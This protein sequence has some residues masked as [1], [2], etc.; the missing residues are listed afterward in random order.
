VTAWGNRQVRLR[1]SA[2]VTARARVRVTH[3]WPSTRWGHRVQSMTIMSRVFGAADVAHRWPTLP[4]L[5]PLVIAAAPS[6]GGECMV[7]PTD[8]PTDLRVMHNGAPV[9]RLPL[10]PTLPPHGPVGGRAFGRVVG[11]WARSSR[12]F[13]P[14]RQAPHGARRAVQ[15]VCTGGAAEA[16]TGV[17]VMPRGMR[18]ADFF[19][20]GAPRPACAA[21]A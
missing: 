11:P 19:A 15:A 2:R 17:G 21:T 1:G 8:A 6:D 14:G 10:I 9:G 12:E 16:L 7:V 5:T 20:R 13:H 18:P 4:R 3:R